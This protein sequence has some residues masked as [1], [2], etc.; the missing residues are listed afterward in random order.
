LDLRF[1]QL[2]GLGQDGNRVF[3]HDIL[4]RVGLIRDSES[5]T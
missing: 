2:D 1:L 3:G 5:G 4:A